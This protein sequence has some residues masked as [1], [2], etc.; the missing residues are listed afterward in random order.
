MKTIKVLATALLFSLC[1]AAC[2]KEDPSPALTQKAY[3]MSAGDI[4]PISGR[5]L[6]GIMFASDYEF[7]ATS[8]NG[9]VY[10]HY[11][12]EAVLQDN[13]NNLQF[14]VNVKPEKDFL[15]D[16]YLES[17]FKAKWGEHKYDVLEKYDYIDYLGNEYIGFM[18]GKD[19]Y[20]SVLLHFNNS[21]KLDMYAI[22]VDVNKGVELIDY[23]AERYAPL[24]QVSTYDYAF[25]H[26]NKFNS[27][28]LIVYI[29]IDIDI[30][31]V[32]FLP[33]TTKSA[34]IEIDK[35]VHTYLKGLN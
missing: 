19:N 15:D 4:L 2:E 27:V 5:N 18:T 10:A 9:K 21:G 33:P 29:S 25:C 6:E 28:D 26:K 17:F 16:E 22:G 35:N 12:G 3:N 13:I 20:P 31:T 34:E 7:V 32:M 23:I 24:A 8:K 30:I 11:V 14:Y 1:L